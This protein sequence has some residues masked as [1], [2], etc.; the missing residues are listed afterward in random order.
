M[1][2]NNNLFSVHGMRVMPTTSAGDSEGGSRAASS[3]GRASELEFDSARE[4]RLPTNCP[5]SLSAIRGVRLAVEQIT[6]ELVAMGQWQ[7]K[8]VTELGEMAKLATDRLKAHNVA[9]VR[10][11]FS[12]GPTS[13]I[14]D[15]GPSVSP[16]IWNDSADRVSTPMVN[17]TGAID[18]LLAGGRAASRECRRRQSGLLLV[19]VSREG[20]G[21]SSRQQSPPGA[22]ISDDSAEG[23]AGILAHARPSRPPGVRD[24]VGGSP[25]SSA[26]ASIER[27]G[28]QVL[29]LEGPEV[30]SSRGRP[31]L[32]DRWLD[33][34]PELSSVDGTERDSV[35]PEMS[36]FRSIT[37]ASPPSS[38]QLAGVSLED[39]TDALSSPKI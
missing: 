4:S 16:G 5:T 3:F 34:L 33:D 12:L 9:G 37:W 32:D 27:A 2:N 36:S 38:V 21:A 35:G 11:I 20:R 26:L 10:S 29:V 6:L 31:S 17:D 15:G 7:S 39:F 1:L 18:L 8:M 25:S 24:E 13:M 23:M 22:A 14:D 28:A 19:E 30:V